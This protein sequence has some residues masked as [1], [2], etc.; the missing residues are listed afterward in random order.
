MTCRPRTLPYL[1]IK[2]SGWSLLYI[3]DDKFKDLRPQQQL[4]EYKDWTKV[5][6][7][8]GGIAVGTIYF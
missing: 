6:C 5:I 1:D 4:V 7:K 3:V 8:V 2:E